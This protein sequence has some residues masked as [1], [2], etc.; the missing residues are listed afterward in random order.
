MKDSEALPVIMGELVLL[1]E[2]HMH[3]HP[4]KTA[5]ALVAV[6]GS[7]VNKLL[8]PEKTALHMYTIA[9]EFAIRAA[10]KNEFSSKK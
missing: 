2:K 9:D 8:G 10:R 7:Y 6:T 5:K 1:V 4:D 3:N